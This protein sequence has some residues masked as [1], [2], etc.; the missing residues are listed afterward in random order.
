MKACNFPEENYETIAWEWKYE[1]PS[2]IWK[3]RQLFTAGSRLQ[4]ELSELA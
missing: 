3:E 1:M 2:Q 4:E